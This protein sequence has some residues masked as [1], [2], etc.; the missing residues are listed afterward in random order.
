MHTNR[1]GLTN[2]M[3]EMCA[4]ELGDLP[5]GDFRACVCVHQRLKEELRIPEHL[6][7]RCKES[8]IPQVRPNLLPNGRFLK[9]LCPDFELGFCLASVQIW[10]ETVTP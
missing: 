5:L 4:R 10:G 7:R 8:N 3:K 9:A 2:L 6:Q 1:V